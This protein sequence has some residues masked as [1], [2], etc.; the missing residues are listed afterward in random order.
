M[1]RRFIHGAE[2]SGAIAYENRH[3]FHFPDGHGRTDS[4]RHELRSFFLSGCQ[5]PPSLTIKSSV[6]I[7]HISFNLYTVL[8]LS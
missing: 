8:I 2:G 3:H 5:P 4:N 6:A 1:G 7:C